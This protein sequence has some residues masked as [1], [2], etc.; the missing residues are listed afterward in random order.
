MKWPFTIKRKKCKLCR[1]VIKA[2]HNVHEVRVATGEG[3]LELEVCAGCAF[4]L[5]K[6]ADVLTKQRPKKEQPDD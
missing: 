6:S 1:K 2:K 4:V 3:T 5:D